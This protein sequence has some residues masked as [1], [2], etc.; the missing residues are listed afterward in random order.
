MK[1]LKIIGDEKIDAIG[2]RVVHGG[3]KYHDATKIT[4][5]VKKTIETF[6]F[7]Q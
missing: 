2:H 4:D 5:N 3:E 6:G 1:A 7:I